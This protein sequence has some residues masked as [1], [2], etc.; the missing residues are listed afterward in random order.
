MGFRRTVVLGQAGTR[1]IQKGQA[2]EGQKSPGKHLDTWEMVDL[3][4]LIWL[5]RTVLST[6]RKFFTPV[7]VDTGEGP[8]EFESPSTTVDQSSK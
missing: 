1:A 4:P 3:D 2:W 5:P 8:T 7:G 6:A